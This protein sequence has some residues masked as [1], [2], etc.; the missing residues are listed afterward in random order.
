MKK[1]K[2]LL[3]SLLIFLLAFS[4]VVSAQVNPDSIVKTRPKVGFVMSG[5]GAKG[6]AYIGLIKVMHEAGLEVDYVAG[7]SIGSIVAGFYA[8]GYHPDTM[9]KVIREQN[10]DNLLTDK[11]ERKYIAYEEKEYGETF[12][13]SLPV[14]KKG[15][16]IKSALYEGQEVNMLLNR[17]YSPAYHVKD[18]SKLQTP[19]FC[20][21]TDLL[22]GDAVVLDKGYLPMAIR[23]SMSIP[24]YFT[25]TFYNDKY[26]VDGGVVDNYPVAIAKKK[27]AQYIIGGDVQSGLYTSIEEMN[28]IPTVIDQLIGYHRIKANEIGYKQ[29]NLYVRFKMPYGM[30][31]FESYDSIIDLGERV[32]RE[33]YA[34]IKALADSLNAIEYKPLKEY[35]ARPLDSIYISKVVVEGYERMPFSYF[36]N[37]LDQFNNSWVRIDEL[38][39]KIHLMYGSSFFAH[40]FYEFQTEGDE[41]NLLIKVEDVSLGSLSVGAHYDTDYSVSILLNGAFRN[42]LGKSSKIFTDLVVGP[43]PRLRALYFKDNGGKLGYGGQI[44]MYYFGWNDYGSSTDPNAFVGT[45][46]FTNYTASLFASTVFKNTYKFR[47]GG[48]YEYFRFKSKMEGDLP[49]SLSNFNSYANLFFSFNSDSRDKP[50]LSTKGVKT[51]LKAEYVMPLSKDWVDQLFSNSLV[52]WLNYKQWIPLSKKI[53]LIPSVFLGGTYSKN[54]PYSA[55]QNFGEYS[56]SPAQHWFYLGGQAKSNYIATFRPFTGVDFVQRYGLYQAIFG[57]DLQYNFYK[58]IYFTLNADV[59]AS[60]FYLEDIFQGE[61]LIVG[62][63]GTLSY[64][65]FVG[66]IELSVVGSNIHKYS[67][68]ISLGYWF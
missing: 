24:G 40:V 31:E 32:G 36:E 56:F 48:T 61:N 67:F 57:A 46:Y 3:K 27:G 7:S 19:F 68:F 65:S 18:F 8:L 66:P 29:T 22:T 49:D 43:N 2:L 26:L 54:Y 45:I 42:V 13:L 30:M 33:H 11:I 35:K 55:D 12:I 28:T 39:E 14:N 60:E 37:M 52:I 15:V 64:D 1:P 51:E 10:W 6:F 34:E 47:A 53:T 16:T 21:G 63:G 58:K 38:E 4:F 23:S 17:F 59:G 44:D 25:P 20:I 9:L 50:Y 5:G 41:T 62:Y